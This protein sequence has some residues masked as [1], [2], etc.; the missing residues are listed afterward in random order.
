[1]SRAEKAAATRKR[2]LTAAYELFCEQGYR[3]TTMDA[4]ADRAGVA[5]QTLYFTF[6]TKDEMFQEV[7]EW[8]VL[9]DDPTPPPLQPWYLAAVAADE[10]AEAVRHICTGVIG[11]SRR[12]APMIPA[13]HAVTG[14]PAGAVWERAERLRH[15]GMVDLVGA[16]TKKAPLRKGVTKAQAADV[17]YLLLGPDI[18][19]TM[20]IERGWTEKRFV[21]FTER[22]ALTELFGV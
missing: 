11:I 16:L 6:H 18:Y 3:A 12:V 5:V 17:L 10:V 21:A 8:T 9:G 14:D 22:V 19:R 15:E 4:I 1:M 7:H 20:V 2:M 13:F